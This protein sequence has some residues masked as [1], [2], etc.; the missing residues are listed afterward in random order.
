MDIQTTLDWIRDDFGFPL[1]RSGYLVVREL[2]DWHVYS[3]DGRVWYP[4]GKWD[5]YINPRCMVPVDFDFDSRGIL[6][7]VTGVCDM[8]ARHMLL[9]NSP[10]PLTGGDVTFFR[11][12]DGKVIRNPLPIPFGDW[13]SYGIAFDE[14]HNLFLLGG[15]K[16]GEVVLR[17]FRADGTEIPDFPMQFPDVGYFA[18][19]GE[20]HLFSAHDRVGILLSGHEWIELDRYGVVL[21]RFAIHDSQLGRFAF[22]QDG[23]LF[24]QRHAT[25]HSS[26]PV[27]T[28]DQFGT[29]KTILK[30]DKILA[31]VDGNR[32]V[33]MSPH[34]GEPI[35][36][37][38]VDIPPE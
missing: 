22:T 10:P 9:P 30:S 34:R 33:F 32:F 37:R 6:A 19:R 14:N 12:S 5:A 8:S 23:R 21:R 29:T 4:E 13:R 26:G 3:P 27:V 31:G 25:L 2:P 24:A 35:G 38:L 36:L 15:T 11:T 1:F 17:H 20:R 18:P 7:A 28:F 16:K